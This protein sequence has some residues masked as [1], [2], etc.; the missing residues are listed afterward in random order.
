M[1]PAQACHER[2]FPIL[3]FQPMRH[4][5]TAA[6]LGK[7]D[8]WG[9]IRQLLKLRSFSPGRG[10]CP[11][12][13]TDFTDCRPSTR[14]RE[15]LWYFAFG[16]TTASCARG[17]VCGRAAINGLGASTQTVRPRDP[18]RTGI[19]VGQPGGSPSKSLRRRTSSIP[20]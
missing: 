18:Q 2:E 14:P 17:A 9:L 5:R 3:E 12:A 11:G 1:L 4:L 15:E 6:A 13:F 7:G 10:G 8:R 16:C 19:R 20:V